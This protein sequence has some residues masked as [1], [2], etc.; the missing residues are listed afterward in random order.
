MR[1]AIRVTPGFILV[2][3]WFAAVNSWRMLGLILA[4]SIVH[5]L[6]HY[7]LLKWYRAEIRGFQINA[8][9]AVLD[10]DTSGLSYGEEF[11]AVAAGPAANFLCASLL[12][13]GQKEKWNVWIG[14]NIVLCVFNLLPLRLLDGGRMLYLL[15]SW[16]A[17][18]QIGELCLRW[19][20]ML[21]A[22]LIF[23]GLV[24]VI[25][26]TKGSFWLIPPATGLLLTIYREVRENKH[27]L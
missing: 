1:E 6:G 20:G 10:A 17:G 14:C 12:A 2:T 18:P 26:W 3:F 19:L 16:L 7:L 15:V 8:L 25:W 22:G 11:L 24:S 21:F 23:V 5:E 27:F 4:F 13:L 9:G